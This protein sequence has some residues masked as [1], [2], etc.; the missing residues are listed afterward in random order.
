MRR[1]GSEGVKG[2]R[3]GELG[4]VFYVVGVVS[5]SQLALQSVGSQTEL[6]L[7]LIENVREDPSKPQ[8]ECVQSQNIQ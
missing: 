5:Q 3:E 1:S 2:G 8:E 6:C 4:E 7:N